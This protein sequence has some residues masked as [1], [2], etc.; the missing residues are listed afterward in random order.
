MTPKFVEVMADGGT[1]LTY[2][3]LDSRPSMIS[4]I[5]LT[6]HQQTLKGLNAC[7]W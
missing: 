1:L 5:A 4:T 6:V 7:S 3:G 2:R